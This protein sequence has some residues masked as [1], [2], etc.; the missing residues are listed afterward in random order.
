MEYLQYFTL[1]WRGRERAEIK[2]KREKKRREQA[3]ERIGLDEE[4]KIEG[5]SMI[6]FLTSKRPGYFSEDPETPKRFE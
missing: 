2:E 4:R 5:V 3:A 6:Y 1:Y